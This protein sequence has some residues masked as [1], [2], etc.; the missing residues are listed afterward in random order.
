[1][2]TLNMVALQM[3][4]GKRRVFI[5]LFPDLYRAEVVAARLEWNGDWSPIFITVAVTDFRLSPLQDFRHAQPANGQAKKRLESETRRP[6]A[7]PGNR[8]RACS[9][10][11]VASSV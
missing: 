11:V 5:G 3:K 6:G 1:V 7:N 2:E 10:K 8:F 4:R 9:K